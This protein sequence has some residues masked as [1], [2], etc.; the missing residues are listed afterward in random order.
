[1]GPT[2]RF[3]CVNDVYSLENLPRLRSLVVHYAE[4]DRPDALLV[5]LAGDFVAPSILS[6]L[7][8]GRGMV[9]C[10]K[11]VGITHAIL[12]NHEDDIA[13]AELS[14]RLAE[15]GAKCLGTNVHGFEP[16]LPAFDVVEVGGSPRRIRVG[17][18]GVVM[19]DAAVYRRKPFRRRRC[20][21][22]ERG[23]HARSRAPHA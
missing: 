12:G 13:T 20:G 5:T 18:V 14:K 17:L 8:S 22:R 7:D 21:A 23:C 1:M 10:M 15:L 19:N 2:I 6:S 11:A 4:V 9:E 3:V 16:P